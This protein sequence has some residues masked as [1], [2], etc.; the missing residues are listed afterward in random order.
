MYLIILIVKETNIVHYTSIVTILFTR[1]RFVLYLIELDD[2]IIHA[3]NHLCFFVIFLLS[4]L[5]WIAL[6]TVV[7]LELCSFIDNNIC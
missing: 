3:L 6:M 4:F 2:T 7:L 5:F 1:S